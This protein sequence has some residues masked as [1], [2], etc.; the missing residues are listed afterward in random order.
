M[1]ISGWFDDDLPGTLSNWSLMQRIGTA[2]Q[3][4]VLGSVEARL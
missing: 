3:R 4:L 1:Q 2:P